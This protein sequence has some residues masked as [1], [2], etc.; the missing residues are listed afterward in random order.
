MDIGR[1]K[2]DTSPMIFLYLASVDLWLS[3]SSGETEAM[4][5]LAAERLTGGFWDDAAR[6]P[7]EVPGS[8]RTLTR[9]GMDL[10]GAEGMTDLLGV[11]LER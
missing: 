8:R 5:R 11:L 4:M 6:H 1:L 9:M 2:D 10:P 3:E 7:S